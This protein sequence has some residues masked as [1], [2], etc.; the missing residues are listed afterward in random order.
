M[1]PPITCSAARMRSVAMKRSATMPTKNGEIIAATAVVPAASPI[2][3]PEKCNVSP[4]HVPIVTYHAPQTKYWRN[5]IAD[6]FNRTDDDIC[7]LS[8]WKLRP[9]C[10]HGWLR[11]DHAG[12]HVH[13]RLHV[14]VHRGQ[15]VLV[16]DAHD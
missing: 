14:L 1:A 15:R 4:S 5:I 13:G 3:S 2:C 16:L 9:P 12:Q 7:G 8:Q 11:E 10:F 6:S